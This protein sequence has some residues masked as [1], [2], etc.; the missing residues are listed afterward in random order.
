MKTNQ[1]EIV[2]KIKEEYVTKEYSQ[3]NNLRDLDKK[4]KRPAIIFTYTL[5][6]LSSII[7]GSGMSLIMTDI[8]SKIGIS[9]NIIIGT[10]IGLIALIMMGIN[11]PLY[12]KILNRRRKIYADKI[13]KISNEI[14]E[15]R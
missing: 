6:I 15:T 4:V 12:K 13:I 5:G 2:Q 8:G 14:L 1:E 10:I 3:L 9:H 11:Y 7:L